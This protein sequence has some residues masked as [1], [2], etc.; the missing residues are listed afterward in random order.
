MS[1]KPPPVHPTEIRTS[2]SPS[3]VVELNTTSVLA[4]YA[5][6]AGNYT[7]TNELP[8]APK[9]QAV[10]GQTDR[11]I[12][13]CFWLSKEKVLLRGREFGKLARIR[14]I[15]SSATT[16]EIYLLITCSLTSLAK[17]RVS[18]K[19]DLREF[20]ALDLM[21]TIQNS[22]LATNNYLERFTRKDPISS[23][24][25]FWNRFLSFSFTPP[26]NM[27]EQKALDERIEGLCRQLMVNN[28]QSG[29]FGSLLHVFLTRASELLASAQTDNNMF[30]WQTYNALFILRCLTKYFVENLKEEDLVRQF[31]ARPKHTD[32]SHHEDEHV[33][34]MEV[35]MDSLIEIIV[36]VPVRSLMQGRYSI[37]SPLLV[38]TLL[39]HFI[40]QQQAPPGLLGHS[41][42]GSLVIGLAC[43][44]SQTVWCKKISD[45]APGR[46]QSNVNKTKNLFAY[47]EPLGISIA[48]KAGLWN[49]L[50][51]GLAR[52]SPPLLGDGGLSLEDTPLAN[53]SLLLILVLANHCTGEKNLHNPYRQALFSFTNSLESGEAAPTKASATFKLDF[54][55]LFHTLCCAANSD[56]TTLLLY[57]LVHRNHMVK[58]FILSRSDIELLV[59][60][61]L[62]TL[63]HAPD[64]NSHHIYMSLIIL[65]I[66]SE[67]DLFNKT[68][69]ESMLKGVTW[70][71]ERSISE[72]SLGG[73][74]V[75]VV[76]RT[77]QYNML[78]MRFRN[79]HPYVSQRLVSL[80][81]TLSRKHARL[82]E[83]IHQQ[84]QS[85]V[86]V[87]IEGPEELS[88]M[89][90][91]TIVIIVMLLLYIY[92]C[93][94]AQDLTVLEEVLRMVLEI[95]NSCLSHQLS[96]NPNLIYTL[97]YKRN[98]FEP[99]RTHQAF[100]D[101]VNNIDAVIQFFSRKLDQNNSDLSV[102]E[103][104]ATIQQ[105]ALQWP[106]ERLKK[107]PD[108]KFK[109]VEED[110]PE[111]F[112][113][114]YVW[115][116][117]CRSSGLYWN[118]T[119][120]KLFSA[121][122]GVITI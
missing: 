23:N 40:D 16:I 30:S 65:L 51:L 8:S 68:I 73:L 55:Q 106:R 29:N 92:V 18:G 58:N 93:V 100:Q 63:Y 48:S 94:C 120:I 25:P 38:K 77:I 69:H 22:D 110:Q 32:G 52:P 112:F 107:F 71:T 20:D 36:D 78:K 111:D 5:T 119:N 80:F 27:L 99:F 54:S 7:V 109:Y 101:I 61:I 84:P 89:V 37:H 50:T 15:A 113:I 3:S 12:C 62:K 74:L 72:I 57:L 14:T 11:E 104:L 85:Q 76:I 42:G 45:E 81:E 41:S 35:F 103:V 64:S 87:N 114:P 108:L 56:Q 97:L 4:N 10:N 86:T 83:Q 79:L 43:M 60:R 122:G 53:L 117:V 115:S 59:V 67:D 70:Y 66:L 96:H 26:S 49:M 33:N 90:S 116:L 6:E 28:L 31:E 98:I 2:I 34:R 102:T 121:D 75:L 46:K 95:L 47:H 82:A 21:A 44:V 24:D 118:P 9:G 13:C 1:K 39:Q 17:P 88:D 91:S 105:G 19:P